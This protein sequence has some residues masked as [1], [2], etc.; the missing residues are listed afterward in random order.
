VQVS[1]KRALAAVDEVVD[2]RDPGPQTRMS[3]RDAGV[4]HRHRDPLP[5]LDRCAASARIGAA[6]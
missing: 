1:R 5:V 6:P 2:G 4:D 3:D